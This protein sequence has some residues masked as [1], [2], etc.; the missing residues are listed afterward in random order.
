MEQPKEVVVE[1]AR[2]QPIEF[3]NVM[4][5]SLAWV[6]QSTTSFVQ[7]LQPQAF[8]NYIIMQFYILSQ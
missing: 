1:R 8:L 6:K 7:Y 3:V 5:K 2:I 4:Y